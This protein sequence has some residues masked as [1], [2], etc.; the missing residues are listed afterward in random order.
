MSKLAVD[1]VNHIGLDFGA[2]DII[3]NNRDD[4]C[5]LLEVNTAP[6][7]QGTTLE[8]YKDAVEKYCE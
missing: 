4:V 1:C 7:L 5:Y 3:Y 2:V 8:K 6:G